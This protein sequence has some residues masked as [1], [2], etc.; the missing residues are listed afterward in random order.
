MDRALRNP[1]LVGLTG[2]N[3]AGKSA[4]A[5]HLGTLSFAY[6]SLSD[7]VREEAE[8][9]GLE[10]TRVHL[11]AIGNELRRREGAA[12]LAV[13]IGPRLATRD[14]IDS[15]RNPAE[16]AALRKLPGFHLLGVDA[17]MALRFERSRSRGRVG[18]GETLDVFRR[19][20]ELEN[21]EDPAAQQLRAT[22]ALAEVTL[23]NQGSLEDLHD[24]V[25]RLLA[26]WGG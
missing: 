19:R 10:P 8:R 25:D 13:R 4:V 11:I 3:A 1:L 20:E 12:A 24:Q 2:P 7:I 23:R 22:L 9:Q 18:D 26:A 17:P 5:S 6:H 16:V 14:V 21:T 15:I